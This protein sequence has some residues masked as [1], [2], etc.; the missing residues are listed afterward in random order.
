MTT[1]GRF[2]CDTIY[3][4][5][6]YDVFLYDVNHSGKRNDSWEQTDYRA[7]NWAT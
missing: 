3:D 7:L 6:I 1:F 2:E 4:M 5:G